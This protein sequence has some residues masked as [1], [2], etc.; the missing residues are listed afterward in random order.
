MADSLYANPY[1]YQG[2]SFVLRGARFER[3]LERKAAIFQ[4]FE[5]HEILIVE[6]PT[7]LFSHRGQMADLI[8]RVKG[9]TEVTNALG[10]V[11]KIPKAEYLDVFP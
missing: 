6:L 7:Q 8:V 3:M 9:I 2:R 10:I 11:F 5:G 1:Q 4:T